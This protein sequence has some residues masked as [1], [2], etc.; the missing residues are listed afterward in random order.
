LPHVF[1]CPAPLRTVS[2]GAFYQLGPLVSSR[3]LSVSG[4]RANF[5]TSFMS[6]ASFLFYPPKTSSYAREFEL[7]G[8]F[9]P[10]AKRS[11]NL[12]LGLPLFIDCVV[13][14]VSI[15]YLVV[16]TVLLAPGAPICLEVRFIMFL[17][18]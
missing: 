5:Q 15:F 17:R 1:S 10:I 12:L 11:S 18:S 3:R 13:S 7:T 8:A 4:F 2:F 14:M 9:L 16:E 6:T